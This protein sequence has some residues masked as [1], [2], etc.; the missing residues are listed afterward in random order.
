MVL[1]EDRE[2]ALARG[3]RIYAEL[4]GYGSSCDAGHP[5]DPDATGAGPARAMRLAL[6]DA[7]LTPADVGYVNAHATSTTAGDIAEARAIALAGLGGRRDLVH[8]V[9][10]RPR[11]RR[12]GRAGGG[13]HPHGVR[14]ATSCRRRS[15]WRTPSPRRRSTTCC[16]ARP[17]RIGAA[18]SNSFGFGG[19]NACLVFTRHDGLGAS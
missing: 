6:E 1:L 3:A 14:A 9:G 11:A 15:T 16:T 4:A 8:Q 2:H 12:R 7:G 17:A 13:R 19:H 10:P 18:I 5:T